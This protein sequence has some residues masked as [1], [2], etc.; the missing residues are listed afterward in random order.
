MRRPAHSKHSLPIVGSRRPS[1]LTDPAHTRQPA[2]QTQL[3]V[4]KTESRRGL[5]SVARDGG[6]TRMSVPSHGTAGHPLRPSLSRSREGQRAGSSPHPHRRSQRA[7]GTCGTN[8]RPRE[9]S[10]RR[11]SSGHLPPNSRSKRHQVMKGQ[12]ALC[13]RQLDEA[14]HLSSDLARREVDW[15]PRDGANVGA[16]RDPGSLA[17]NPTGCRGGRRLGGTPSGGSSAFGGGANH[18]G[19]EGGQ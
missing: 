1:R 16:Q 6:C 9:S 12:Q 11:R 15:A 5:L 13:R 18:A 7:S 14:R 8:R 17:A 3:A 2:C 10:R 19:K 4:R